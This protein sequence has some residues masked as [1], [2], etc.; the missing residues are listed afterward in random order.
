MHFGPLLHLYPPN[1]RLGYLQF[2]ACTVHLRS[3]RSRALWTNH[4]SAD[5]HP[6]SPHRPW[7]VG[8]QKC[9]QNLQS[10]QILQTNVEFYCLQFVKHF[11]H[12]SRSKMANCPNNRDVET[13]NSP[14]EDAEQTSCG[15]E[16]LDNQE[17]RRGLRQKVQQRLERKQKV[18][19]EADQSRSGSG[20]LDYQER[21]R[22]LR[23]KVQ[24]RLERKRKLLK[25]VET[26]LQELRELPKKFPYLFASRHAGSSRTSSS[27]PRSPPT[28]SVV[29]DARPRQSLRH[30]LASSAAVKHEAQVILYTIAKRQTPMKFSWKER[31][32]T[33]KLYI[34]IM[35]DPI[36]PNCVTLDVCG[37]GNRT[38]PH[39]PTHCVA[40]FF[41]CSK[42][43]FVDSHP[44]QSAAT[45][46]SLDPVQ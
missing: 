21:R 7:Q 1:W 39:C 19:K 38:Q 14:Q 35:F 30:E 8:V 20:M 23:Q 42:Y 41:F 5:L 9:R 40:L 43:S 46:G 17:R 26:E 13:S 3:V 6:R 27:S 34:T 4:N 11:Q 16:M 32:F 24:Q 22:R 33:F 15:S 28:P 25:K 18:L 29:V 10:I 31:W 45:G 37:Y 44:R 36:L 12:C 2:C